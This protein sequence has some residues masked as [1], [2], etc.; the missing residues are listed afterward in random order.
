MSLLKYF[1]ETELPELL[2]SALAGDDQDTRLFKTFLNELK[3]APAAR[4]APFDTMDRQRDFLQAVKRGRLGVAKWLFA[5]MKR[6]P[7]ERDKADYHLVCAL[8][9]SGGHL[10]I[11]KWARAN[12]CHWDKNPPWDANNYWR[13]WDN[14]TC[15]NAAAGGHLGVL[16]WA[17]EN[18][19]WWNEMTCANAAYGGHMGVLQWARENGC[20]W[21]EKT[22][23]Y[24]AF[25]GHVEVLKWARENGCWWNEY[26]CANLALGGHLEALKWARENGCPWDAGTTANAARGGRLDVLQWAIE[27]GCPEA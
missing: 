27:N 16:Q 10:E 6:A 7:Q 15:A 14:D 20:P 13:F 26:T 8:A 1:K 24:A 4:D 22:C 11:L 21:D 17:H 25:N 19:C 2:S 12:G 23:C 5:C 3:G 9:A 18:G